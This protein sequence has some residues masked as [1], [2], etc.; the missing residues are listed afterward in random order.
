MIDT[1][2]LA[3]QLIATAHLYRLGKHL[4]ASNRIISH[5]ESFEALLLTVPPTCLPQFHQISMN[6]LYAQQRQDWVGLADD[7]EYDFVSLLGQL[8][9][10]QS[11]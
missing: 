7:L 5:T 6:M 10:P 9:N 1:R 4:E 8:N 2:E 11:C 3:G